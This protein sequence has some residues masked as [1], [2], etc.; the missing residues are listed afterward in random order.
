MKYKTPITSDSSIEAK[1]GKYYRQISDKNREKSWLLFKL[2]LGLVTVIV[3]ALLY[4]FLERN[5]LPGSVEILGGTV[6]FTA[7]LIY[8]YGYIK[9]RKELKR[10]QW[11]AEDRSDGLS[12]SP[13]EGPIAEDSGDFRKPPRHTPRS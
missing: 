13:E 2:V 8:L 10:L 1:L 4:S 3:A 6:A 9:D 11:L 7:F 12:L 5:L